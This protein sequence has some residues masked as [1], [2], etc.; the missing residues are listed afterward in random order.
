MIKCDNNPID[1]MI[2][3][4]ICVG[5]DL[6]LCGIVNKSTGKSDFMIVF[7]ANHNLIGS[8]SSFEGERASGTLSVN[9]NILFFIFSY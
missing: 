7:D 1:K 5:W 6:E 8:C 4:F 9:E 2:S 3:L